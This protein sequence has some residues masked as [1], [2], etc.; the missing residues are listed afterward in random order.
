MKLKR[1]PS[2]KE[3]FETLGR[4]CLGKYGHVTVIEERKMENTQN[5]ALKRGLIQKLEC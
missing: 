3:C 1:A 2:L 4:M 5:N